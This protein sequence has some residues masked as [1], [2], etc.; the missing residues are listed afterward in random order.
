MSSENQCTEKKL[1]SGTMTY[2]VKGQ[3]HK[4]TRS[5]RVL[6]QLPINQKR[7]AVVSPKLA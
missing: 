5:V 2:K 7:I 3:G 6:A 1:L 4:V